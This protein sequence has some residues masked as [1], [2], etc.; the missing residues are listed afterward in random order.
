[1]AW[2]DFIDV[3]SIA[4]AC[5]HLSGQ[6]PPLIVFAIFRA[7]TARLLEPGVLRLV[8]ERIEEIVLVGIIMLLGFDIL[9]PLARRAINAIRHPILAA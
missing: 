4:R 3:D 6:L 8:L 1:M 9:A 2:R 7:I 5:F